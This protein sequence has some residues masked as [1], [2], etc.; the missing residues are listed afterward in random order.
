MPL[1][2]CTK[3]PQNTKI[4]RN[5]PFQGL[6]NDAKKGIF[7]F[8]NMASGN[9]GLISARLYN[10]I[11][12]VLGLLSFATAIKVFEKEILLRLYI[13]GNLKIGRLIKVKTCGE[14]VHKV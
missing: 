1:Y 8:E 7:G 12:F 3:W 5:F 10:N 4:Y 6:H 9:P 2:P 11:A 14:K 13:H